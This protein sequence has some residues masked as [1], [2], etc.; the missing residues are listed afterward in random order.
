MIENRKKRAR[1]EESR[2]REREHAKLLS[3]ATRNIRVFK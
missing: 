1:D 2:Q 3:S